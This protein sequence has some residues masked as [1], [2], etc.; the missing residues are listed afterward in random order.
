VP[1][2]DDV[3]TSVERADPLVGTIFDR[4]F[5]VEERIAAGGFGAIYRATHVKSGHQIALKVLLPALAHDLGVVA[6]FRREG[7]ALTQLRCPH[8]ITAYELGQAADRTLFIAMELL[9]G[10]SLFERY[11][12]NGPFEWKR[13][14]R[15]AR[16]VCESLEEA[17]A[18]GI[19]HRDLKPTNIHLEKHGDDVDYVKVLDF[20]IA[21]LIGG[22]SLGAA[23]LTNA[24]Q[25]VGTLDYMSPEQMVGGTITGQTDIY[26][27]GIV[28]YEMIAGCTP[29]PEAMTAAQALA[30]VMKTTPQPLYLR[31]PVPEELDRIV[32][33]C[34][35]RETHR[36]YQTVAELRGDLD[37][38]LAG[39]VPDR[40]RS[41]DTRPV[42][43]QDDEATAFT[44]PPERLVAASRRP[45]RP[46]VEETTFTPP[47]EPLLAH[48]RRD[49]W[50]T[51]EATT[52]APPP[53]QLLAQARRAKRPS[54]EETTFTPPPEPLLAESR[55][56][57]RPSVED[58]TFT[59]PPDNM[60]AE[61]RTA[62]RLE[63]SPTHEWSDEDEFAATV[64]GRREGAQVRPTD[65]NERVTAVARLADIVER[66]AAT[67]GSVT[68]HAAARGGASEHA[69]ARGGA[70]EHAAARG[71]ASERAVTV[72]RGGGSERARTV[73]RGDAM[74][75]AVTVPRGDASERATS[76]PARD[77]TTP[78]LA[79]R[80]DSARKPD[81]APPPVPAIARKPPSA[82]PANGPLGAPL[83]ARRP[84][85]AAAV[86]RTG[87]AAPRD[88]PVV[89]IVA[90]P[91]STPR[92]P[93]SQPPPAYPSPIPQPSPYPP[94]PAPPYSS[95][96]PQPSS[97]SQPPPQRPE[98]P[99]PAPG[100]LG[101]APPLAPTPWG[102][103]GAGSPSSQIQ[104]GAQ[105][106]D[107]A[108]IAAREALIRRLIWIA[109]IVVAVAVG[110]IL[111][112]QL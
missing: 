86:Q 97:Y 7:D 96:V 18:L 57:K 77:S 55:R 37:R 78:T 59:P 65:D 53:A 23:D 45:R 76:Q 80:L 52:A 27:L 10:E 35:E 34:L 49:D 83:G 20:G 92:P 75:R 12:T 98:V 46:S 21:K 112:T 3:E 111:A 81:S 38:L 47:P 31:A 24:G 108:R 58:T 26:T 36:R 30:A 42:A 107:M 110:V 89:P 85:D 62:S 102:P 8:T 48:A 67:R 73:P 69:A 19:V 44:P 17:H 43:K 61:L 11:K 106:F 93:S 54:V 41:L 28:M 64:R 14:V 91:F 2:R 68:E 84:E 100:T 88:M 63:Q 9:R 13:M 103:Q 79:R 104:R 32:M 90:A 39:V 60:L 95:P 5:R 87:M 25:M 105:G 82:P 94:Q 40:A 71:G 29:F 66:A 99:L 15:I 109:A 56:A 33:K 74:E 1:R 6:R 22:G 70:S 50:S 72:P 16:Q 4:R 51:G 101:A